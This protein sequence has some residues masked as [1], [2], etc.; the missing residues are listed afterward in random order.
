MDSNVLYSDK[1]NF[2]ANQSGYHMK[3]KLTLTGSE[4]HIH[5]G[6]FSRFID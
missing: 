1:T 5:F 2:L 3:Q 6:S 4:G